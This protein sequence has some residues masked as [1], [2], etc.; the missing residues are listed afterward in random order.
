MFRFLLL[1]AIG[2][3]SNI[4]A[5]NSD[6]TADTQLEVIEYTELE[7]NIV[8]LSGLL[9]LSDQV[10]TSAQYMIALST[11]N[12]DLSLA[13]ESKE[14]V[15]EINHAQHFGIAQNL[16]KRWSQ[17]EWQKRLLLIVT[18]FDEKAQ[19]KIEKDLAQKTIRAAQQKE[20]AAISKQDKAEYSLYMN[21]LSQN[22]P[23]KSRWQLVAALDQQSSFSELIITTRG[24]VYKEISS[25]VK[26]WQPPENWQAEAKQEVLEFLFY[27]YRKTPNAELKKIASSYNSPDLKAFLAKVKAEL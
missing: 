4:F 2:L 16:S 11:P 8:A 23:A 14:D 24:L 7:H 26:G 5:Q 3:S 6:L 10:K 27:A 12:S 19:K 25:Q 9:S 20:K 13:D 22:P 21:K 1:L 18:S 15:I 17:T